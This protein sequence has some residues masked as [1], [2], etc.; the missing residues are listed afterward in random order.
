MKNLHFHKNGSW[1]VPTPPK[2]TWSGAKIL[3]VDAALTRGLRAGR[4]PGMGRL[5]AEESADDICSMIEGNN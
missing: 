5:A 1:V 4:D 3:N 2:D